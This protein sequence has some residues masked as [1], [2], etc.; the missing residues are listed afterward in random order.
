MTMRLP[1]DPS[2]DNLRGDFKMV[3]VPNADDPHS[4]DEI[5]KFRAEITRH[6]TKGK[7]SVP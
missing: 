6:A 2:P 7:R 4:K 1:G 3:F 5:I